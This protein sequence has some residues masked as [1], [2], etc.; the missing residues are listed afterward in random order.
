MIKPFL[1]SMLLLTGASPLYAF[2]PEEVSSHFGR[3]TSLTHFKTIGDR[4]R[5]STAALGHLDPCNVDDAIDVESYVAACVPKNPELEEAFFFCAGLLRKGIAVM[6]LRH[7]PLL[8]HARH[9]VDVLAILEVYDDLETFEAKEELFNR[10]PAAI[11]AALAKAPKQDYSFVNVDVVFQN[12]RDLLKGV[13]TENL[14]PSAQFVHEMGKPNASSPVEWRIGESDN[15]EESEEKEGEAPLFFV[16]PGSPSFGR[17][18]NRSPSV[19]KVAEQN[20]PISG[21]VHSGEGL[22]LQPRTLRHSSPSVT[23][24]PPGCRRKLCR[25]VFRGKPPRSP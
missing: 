17:A 12:M 23:P 2:D 6:D 8:R 11:A 4:I 18:S 15:E 7:R 25:K 21:R 13:D 3:G 20:P 19:R 10:I 5:E 9:Y 22:P 14:A 1:L 24:S 16:D